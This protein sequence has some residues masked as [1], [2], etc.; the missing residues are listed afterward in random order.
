MSHTFRRDP[1]APAVSPFEARRL[2]FKHAAA[3]A[4]KRDRFEARRLARAASWRVMALADLD[5][6]PLD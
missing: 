6:A 4:G 2:G 5:A 1:D 3:L